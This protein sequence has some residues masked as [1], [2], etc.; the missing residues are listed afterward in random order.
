GLALLGAFLGGL[1]GLALLG[2]GLEALLLVR[3][4]FGGAE[5][6]LRPR[7]PGELLPVSGDLE[8]DAD[9]VGGLRAHRE[10]VLH[11][12]GVHFNERGIGLRVILADLLDSAPVALGARVRDDDPVVGLTDLAQALQLDLD[13]HGCGLL[14]ALRCDAAEPRRPGNSRQDRTDEPGPA[15]EERASRGLAVSITLCQTTG[16]A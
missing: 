2:R 11:P 6:A 14:P 4:R 1:A 16:R 8:Q 9:R 12:L 5:G 10:P 7:F 15:N 13:S 3:A